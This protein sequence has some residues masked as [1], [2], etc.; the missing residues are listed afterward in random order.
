M[1]R[2]SGTSHALHDDRLAFRIVAGCA[3]ERVEQLLYGA[4]LFFK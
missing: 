1:A 2:M 3:L 4:M